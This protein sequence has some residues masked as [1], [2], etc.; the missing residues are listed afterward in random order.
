M[1]AYG[2][3]RGKLVKMADIETRLSREDLEQVI[4]DI[5]GKGEIRPWRFASAPESIERRNG[6]L[7]IF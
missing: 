6:V 3:L 1:P 7:T 2:K 4:V 5:P